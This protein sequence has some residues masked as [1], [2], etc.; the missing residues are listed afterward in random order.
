MD[1]NRLK[2]LKK[3][4]PFRFL[5]MPQDPFTRTWNALISVLLIYVLFVLS[6]EL[7]FIKDSNLFFEISEYVTSVIFLVD[8]VVNFNLS[9]QHAKGH[10]VTSRCLIAQRYLKFW[11][12]I[13]LVSSFP[14]YLVTDSRRNS[15]FQGIKTIKIFRYFKIVR[16]LR[17]LK[18]VKRFFPGHLRNRAKRDFTKFKSNEERMTQHLFIAGIFAHCFACL[19][20][21][22]PV[23]L[24]PDL[25]WVVLR[26]LQ[27]KSAFEKYLFS[28]HWVVE[29]MITVGF[30][31]NPFQ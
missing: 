23:Y 20:Y 21:S 9:F 7:A 28:L 1:T 6:F 4:K 3:A 11:F 12:W 25:N 17:L 22:V 16:V 15:M 19:F 24:S 27:V 13:D 14:F 30:G 10:W 26:G 5:F 31:E 18:F 29:T 2:Q 8:I